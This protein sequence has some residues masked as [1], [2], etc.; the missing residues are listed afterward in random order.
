MVTMMTNGDHDDQWCPWW[1]LWPWW[2]WDSWRCFDTTGQNLEDP[3]SRCTNVQSN[4]S[5]GCGPTVQS[6]VQCG[7]QLS[8]LHIAHSAYNV[9][10]KRGLPRVLLSPRD[11]FNCAF[12]PNLG[13]QLSFWWGWWPSVMVKSHL[14]KKVKKF[15]KISWKL[16]HIDQPKKVRD[17]LGNKCTPLLGKYTLNYVYFKLLA[18]HISPA[19]CTTF[20]I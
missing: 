9:A 3:L 12:R 14:F 20:L 13:H 4:V 8:T 18:S 10:T 19:T 1:P 16:H 15:W 5:M 11:R 6:S 2:P 17:K 7:S